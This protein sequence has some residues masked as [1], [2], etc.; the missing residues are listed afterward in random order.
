MNYEDLL[1]TLC[2]CEQTLRQFTHALTHLLDGRTA[3]VREALR[4]LATFTGVRATADFVH[5][6]A[7]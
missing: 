3:V 1:R 2:A 4:V 5:L 6:R 7:N